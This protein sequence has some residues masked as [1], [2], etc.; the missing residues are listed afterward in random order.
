MPDFMSPKQQVISLKLATTHFLE[1]RK[2]QKQFIKNYVV[3]IDNF[4]LIN[5]FTAAKNKL[6]YATLQT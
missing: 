3:L 6:N 1:H 5:I 4:M 2:M